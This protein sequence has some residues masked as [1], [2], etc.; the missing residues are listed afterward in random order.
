MVLHRGA[1]RAHGPISRVNCD[2]NFLEIDE[3]KKKMDF[4]VVVVADYCLISVTVHWISSLY[5]FI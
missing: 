3:Q 4:V 2:A 5:W 1:F